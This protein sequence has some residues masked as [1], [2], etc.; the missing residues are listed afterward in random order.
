MFHFIKQSLHKIY[1]AITGKLATLFN[2]TAIDADTLEELELI[3]LQADTGAKTTQKII[4]HLKQAHA[5]GAIH[6]GD[7]LKAALAHQLHALLKHEPTI[8]EPDVILLVGINGSGKTTCAAKIAY[9]AHQ[10]GKRC[11]FVAA[12]T[13]R[14]AAPEQLN[15]WAARTNTAIEAG[16]PGQDPA[17]VVFMGC[18]R[19]KQEQFDLLII[20]TAGR[21]QTKTNLMK[22]LE[23]IKRIICKQ[24]PDKTVA[25]YLTIDAMLG[26][27]SFEQAQLFHGSTDLSGVILTKMD[28]TGKGGVIFAIADQLGIPIIYISYGETPQAFKLFDYQTYI[29][30]LLNK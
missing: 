10:A 26:Q 9:Q 4:A 12:D 21:L 29:T 22:E 25:T 30:D 6:S 11:L 5:S 18:A 13:F 28:G 16:A 8:T 20:D 1:T 15:V 24:L 27:N 3:L 19:F 17:S 23:K 7:E 14:A 2:K